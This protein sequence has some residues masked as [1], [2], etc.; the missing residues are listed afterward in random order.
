M[1]IKR[2]GI[3]RGGDTDNYENSLRKGGEIILHIHE[4]LADRWRPVD[5]LIDKSGVWHAGGMPIKPA[6]LISKVD[7]VWNTAHPSFS[8][9]L[10]SLTIPN[11]GV[12]SFPFFLSENRGRLEEHMKAIGVRMPR[13]IVF[14]VY[15]KDFD[16]SLDRYILKTAKAVHEK[17]SPPWIVQSL[18]NDSDIGIHVA[19]TYPQ[20][21]DA[22]EDITNHGKTVLVEEFING[23]DASV[24]TVPGFRNQEIY[25][26]PA[27]GNTSKE[28]KEK[29]DIMAREIYKHLNVCKYLNATFVVHPKRGIFL[30]GIEFFPDLE[31]DSHF[32]QSAKYVGSSP[33]Q[34]VE[35]MLESIL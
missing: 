31:K 33:E 17:F 1:A 20:L 16:I 21:V 4:N 30:K 9:I 8:L 27:I 11:I 25:N 35:H 32:Y 14:P 13:H 2:V 28:E 24:H 12:E 18:S 6:E 10:D 15:Q 3:L 34:I 29:L 23:K 19:N 5:I 22:I 7:V 26:M